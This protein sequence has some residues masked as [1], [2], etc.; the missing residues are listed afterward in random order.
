MFPCSAG[1]LMCYKPP[2]E[3][4]PQPTWPANGVLEQNR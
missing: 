3:G 2:P 4:P 1:P